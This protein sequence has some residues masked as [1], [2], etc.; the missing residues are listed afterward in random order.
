MRESAFWTN[1]DIPWISSKDMKS[2]ILQDTED[3]ITQA[4]ISRSG[5]K[6]LPPNTVVLVAR[7]GILKHTLPV[8]FVPFSTT[9][10]QDVKALIVSENV[11]PKYAYHVLSAYAPR[12]RQIAKKQGGTV[13]SL[14]W[15]AVLGFT[16]PVPS[17]DEQKRII[18]DLDHFDA[19]TND[20]ISGLP[21]E[22]IARRKQYEYY[23]DKL[24]TFPRKRS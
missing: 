21:A 9:I 14:E 16:V 4:A 12:I 19:L 18:R 8:S 20:L 2:P 11:L 7:S 24:L 15:A 5:L 17:I 3:H 1:G 10:N 23:R 13:D 22:I 6:L